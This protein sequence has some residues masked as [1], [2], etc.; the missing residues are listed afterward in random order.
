MGVNKTRT[1]LYTQEFIK[2]RKALKLL[3]LINKAECSQD[4][5]DLTALTE[6]IDEVNSNNSRIWSITNLAYQY[7]ITEI[8]WNV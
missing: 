2:Y 5:E 4:P 7:S 8:P 3:P 1:H 6:A